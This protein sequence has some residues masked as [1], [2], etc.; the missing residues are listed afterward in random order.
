MVKIQGM[1]LRVSVEIVEDPAVT[2]PLRR[3]LA[4]QMLRR[5]G[6]L[7]LLIVSPAPSP[8]DRIN[9]IS[10]LTLLANYFERAGW[11]PPPDC[12]SPEKPND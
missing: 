10:R 11:T 4:K 8:D 1:K 5:D 3:S 12:D 7:A 6:S 2:P 9:V